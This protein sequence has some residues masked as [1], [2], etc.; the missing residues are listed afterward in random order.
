M[1]KEEFDKFYDDNQKVVDDT[2]SMLF[3]KLSQ[4]QKQQINEALK[5]FLFSNVEMM[6]VANGEE[7][8]SSQVQLIAQDMAV[9]IEQISAG[10]VY[11]NMELAEALDNLSI[12]IAFR[13]DQLG[14]S[15]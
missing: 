10:G 6:Q 11:S 5:K 3:P 14:T 1:K 12:D 9:L 2:L 4:E 7:E 13:L 8:D 15:K